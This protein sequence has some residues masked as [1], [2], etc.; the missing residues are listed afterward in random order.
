MRMTT[1][2]YYR[3]T[4]PEAME[5]SRQYTADCVLLQEQAELLGKEF[6]GNPVFYSGVHGRGFAGLKFTPALD[7]PLWTKPEKKFGDVQRIRAS[8]KAAMRPEHDL[9]KTRWEAFKPTARPD[10]AP[11]F[12]A[13]GTDWGQ[14]MFSGIGYTLRDDAVYMTTALDLTEHGQEITGGEYQ[15]AFNAKKDTP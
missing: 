15:A 2:R 5:A 10:T 1:Y 7:S 4:S 8:V 11:L 9:V 12:K 6:G 14:L 13:C 3:F